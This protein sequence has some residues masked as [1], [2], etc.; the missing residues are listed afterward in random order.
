[1]AQ[2]YDYAQLIDDFELGADVG[3]DESLT[4][5]IERRRREFES[6]A[7][8]GSIGIEV[9]FGPKREDFNIG[10]Q[11]QKKNTT[12]YDSRASV[13]DYGAALDK[14]GGGTDLQKAMD[15][16]RYGENV[17]RQNMLETLGNLYNKKGIDEAQSKYIDQAVAFAPTLRE[18]LNQT[19]SL[20]SGSGFVSDLRHKTAAAQ[21]R[22]TLGG[23][24]TGQVAANVLGGIR[25][26][27]QLLTGDFKG[28]GE[29]LKANFQ[30]AR[31]VPVGLTPQE[32]YDYLIA[33]QQVDPGV[34]DPTVD[35]NRISEIVEQQKAAGVPETGLITNFNKPTMADV[36]GPAPDAKENYAQYKA[37]MLESLRKNHAGQK[38][39]TTDLQPDGSYSGVSREI[40]IEDYFNYMLAD[41]KALGFDPI[42]GQAL[43]SGGRV[44]MVSG[45]F[46]KGIGSFFKAG[47]DKIDDIIETKAMEKVGFRS[48][49]D[50]PLS[51]YS[52]MKAPIKLSEMENIPE[53]QLK[54]IL[55]TQELGLYKE[56]PEILKA[57][58]LLERFTK[59]VGGKRVIDYERAE[60][61]LNVKLKG[62]ETLDELFKI[63]FRTR[64]ENR[65]ADGG[66]VGLFM[67]GPALE[68]QALSIY[69]SMNAYGFSDQEI[70]NALEG[71]GLYT[72]GGTTTTTTPVT[73]TQT[74]I[75]NQGGGDGPPNDPPKDPFGG[76]GYSSANFGLGANKD[77]MDYEADAYNVGRTFTGQ[78]NKIGLGF[79]EAFKNIPNTF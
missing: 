62:N 20:M 18:K 4:D 52:E 50:I 51:T 8:G 74:N 10:G 57:A 11:A 6:K 61:I 26:I 71:Q 45:G 35:Q 39:A 77:V 22:D 46:L 17:Q 56:T 33:Q 48:K 28:V 54:K 5:Y 41:K 67:G 66:R 24:I 27:P 79:F 44:G 53:D 3:P 2:D 32:S 23:G 49:D 9:L 58:N 31:D 16:Q 29:D 30:G 63:E 7:E 42:T 59:K 19:K 55:R 14:V 60:D 68:G 38:T 75:I 72:P 1:M 21:L 76:L 25:E 12:P 47:K 36:A 37:R 40:P 13:A 43:A 73:N 34:V 70:A 78:L 69:E 15:I 64:P 65:L